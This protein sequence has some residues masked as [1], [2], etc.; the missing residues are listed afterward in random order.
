MKSKWTLIALGVG[1]VVLAAGVW[2]QMSHVE[3]P[4]YSL[5][6]QAGAFELRDYPPLIVAEATVKGERKLAINEGFRVIADY[7]FGNNISA[8]KVAMT[9]PV[10]QQSSEN[11]AMTAPVTQQSTGDAWTVRFVMPS[12][13]TLDTLPKPRNAA[14]TLKQIEG[15]RMAVIRF[16]GVADDEALAKRTKELGALITIRNLAPLAP[17]T[18]AFYNPPWTLG[19]LRRN[20]VM[21]PVAK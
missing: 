4:K 2:S 1:V 19:F 8:E 11:V 12:Q 9:A 21:I 20:E 10:T 7:I 16:S 5:I 17:A 3:E 15:Q 18:Y 6:E 13:Y 14:V